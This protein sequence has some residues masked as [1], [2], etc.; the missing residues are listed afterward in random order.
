VPGAWPWL[1]LLAHS[2]A[3]CAELGRLVANRRAVAPDQLARAYGGV[4]M[5]ALATIATRARHVNVLQHAVGY[6][7]RVLPAA[8]RPALAAAVG[9]NQRGLLPLI[10]PMRL[11]EHHAC[12][13][14]IRYLR[15]QVYFHPYP[16]D[17][18]LRL[19]M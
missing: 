9:D 7:R 10:A 5:S 13:H 3:R 17:V 6:F 1:Q 19:P 14:D 11:I 15:E 16:H 8:T 4:F 18:R 2:P 12:L